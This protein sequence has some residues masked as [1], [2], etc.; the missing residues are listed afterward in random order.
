MATDRRLD[1]HGLRNGTSRLLAGLAA[2]CLFAL[3]G[4]QAQGDTPVDLELV[5]AIDVSRSI[6]TEEAQL[7]R[8]GYIR[9]FRDPE[10]IHAIKTGMLG[11]IA[12]GY[13]EWAGVDP[14]RVVIDW[15]LIADEASALAF[16][17]RLA[18]DTP[19]PERRTSITKA[20][21][22]ARGWFDGNGFEGTRRVV[23]VSGD[24]PNN[25][26]G[27]VT[28]ARDAA[29][30]DGI[31]INGLPILDTVLGPFATFNIPD[32]DL[33]YRECVIG[34]TGAFYVVAEGFDDFPRAVRRKL[35]LEIANLFPPPAPAR[36]K[37]RLIP[38]Q[39]TQQAPVRVPPPCDIGER[40]W[41]ERYGL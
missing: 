7:Q 16:A 28:E 24:G 8:Q 36:P 40:I 34:G 38:A 13:F 39:A 25:W 6:D 15:T 26:G 18:Q 3:S 29:V 27:L 5:L 10:V 37:P 20:L 19:I 11:R 30:A 23:D 35:I 12:V 2:I 32:L 1:R 33:Y 41:R 31:T 22:F 9:A 14:V 17:D 21:T 4:A